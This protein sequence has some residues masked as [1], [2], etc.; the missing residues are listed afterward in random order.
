[1]FPIFL[2]FLILLSGACLLAHAGLLGTA[3]CT[4]GPSFWCGSLR[5]AKQCSAVPHCIGTVWEHLELPPDSDG[6]C[7]VCKEMVREARDTLENNKTEDALKGVV[8]GACRLVP[9]QEVSTECVQLADEYIPELLQTLASQMNPQIVCATAGLCNSAR[10]DRLLRDHGLQQW[11]HKSQKTASPSKAVASST[12]HSCDDCH[13]FVQDTITLVRQ[14]SKQEL[15]DHLLAIC[16]ELGSV[17]DGCSALVMVNLDDIY[18]FLTNQLDPDDVCNLFGMC[19]DLFQAETKP[20]QLPA[21]GDEQCDF[22]IKVAQHWR[23]VLTSNTTEEEFKQILDGIC[24]QTGKFRNECTSLID[25]FYKPVY[26]WLMNEFNPKQVCEAIGICTN[27]KSKASWSVLYTGLQAADELLGDTSEVTPFRGGW[28]GND[29]HNSLAAEPSLPRVKL[30][31]QLASIK[32]TVA[33]QSGVL[34]GGDQECTM[35]QFTLHFIQNQLQEKATR[36][37]IEAAVKGV[38]KYL[39]KDLN[40]QCDDY[41]D[42]YGDQV[43]ALLEQEIDP[44][45]ICPMLGLCP[46]DSISG[47]HLRPVSLDGSALRGGGDVTCVACEYIMVQVK[48]LLANKTN[49]EAVKEALDKVCSMMPR[50]LSTECQT[51]VDN[52]AVEVIELLVAGI[53][54]GQ[55]CRML[56]FCDNNTVAAPAVPLAPLESSNQLPLSRMFLPR[57]RGADTGVISLENQGQSKVCV[58]CEFALAILEKMILD[59][60]TH[61]ESEVKAAVSQVC[62]LL[63]ATLQED[64]LGFVEQYADAIVQL[65]VNNI[66][67]KAV[68]T[69]LHLCAPPK[70]NGLFIAAAV[71]QPHGMHKRSI[72]SSSNNLDCVM[73]KALFTTQD[74]TA[75][76]QQAMR[77]FCNT[78]LDSG[79]PDKCLSIARTLTAANL[80]K[81]SD[82]TCVALQWCP[83]STGLIGSSQCTWGPTYWCQSVLHATSC[84]GALQHCQEVVWQ[85][86][87]PPAKV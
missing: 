49:Q 35:C 41:V 46:S 86:S 8:E 44:S 16:S 10:I 3:E 51:F 59:N 63:P 53:V 57:L 68:C 73:C 25:S 47:H 37:Q 15:M 50:S 27:I 6:V 42:A 61:I 43:I 18:E 38:C 80:K 87:S 81:T 26:A 77:N 45:I 36:E 17:S 82:R 39:P 4:Y 13:R 54:P 67:P 34:A 40:E 56:Q 19:G 22:C 23:Q 52:N 14:H 72:S 84:G 83:A 5:N 79:S 71:A 12:D 64:C 9:L 70:F 55:I 60:N 62:L 7:D 30:Q 32:I 28:A 76:P 29:E 78:A 33:G 20:A 85:G 31:K 75:D 11:H 2:R 66:K 48:E 1:M 24:Q 58:M 65:I 74:G 21:S 69:D